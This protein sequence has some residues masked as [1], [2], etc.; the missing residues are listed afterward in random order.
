MRHILFALAI[1]LPSASLAEVPL[2]LFPDCGTGGACPSDYDPF[3]EWELGSGHPEQVPATSLVEIERP[4]GSGMWVDRAWSITTGRTDVI[5]AVMDS[6]IEWGQGELLNKHY[7]NA[8]ELPFPQD[9]DGVDAGTYDLN[10]DGVHNMEDWVADPRVEPDSA[11]YID[12]HA[13]DRK[14]PSDLI[15]VF[16]DGVDDDGNGYVDDISGWDFFWNDNDPYDEIQQDGYSHGSKEGRWSVAEGGDGGG[17]IGSCPNCMLLNIRVGDGF[18]ADV[19]HFANA[20]VF[21][22]DSGASVIQ[23]AL[24]TLN[25]TTM[26]V[27]AIEYA[28]DNGVTIIG[29]AADETAWHA[30]MPGANHHVVYTHAIRYD[31]IDREDTSTWFAYSNCTNFGGRL[32]ISVPAEGCSSGG[33]GRGAGVAGLLHSAARDALEAGVIDSALTA[34]EMYQLIIHQVHDIAFNPDDDRPSLYPSHPGWDQYFGY[35]R[36]DAFGAVTA[37]STG[38]IPPEADLLAPAWFTVLNK[39]ETPTVEVRGIAAADRQ[40]S[41]TW[42]LEVAGGMDPRDADFSQVAAGSGSARFEGVLATLDLDDVPVDASAVIEAFDRFDTNVTKVDK[43]HVHAATLRLRVIDG[44]GRLG[45]MRKMIFVQADP[46]LLPGM[47]KRV[48]VS[49]E[50]SLNLVDVDGDG[51]DDVVYV[52]SDGAVHVA[53]ATLTDKPGWPQHVPLL[54]EVD[55]DNPA[56]HLASAGYVGGHVGDQGRHGVVASPA[57]HKGSPV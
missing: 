17:S 42:E 20:A 11:G 41:Y 55:S 5:V 57:V 31:A 15:A 2:P 29:S 45:E 49:V 38:E 19:N 6:G 23:E 7:L 48:A 46:D 25:N 27:E 12:Q 52:T 24:G 54:D 18:V 44:E 16:S 32:D 37:I 40:G 3:G 22:V 13:H 50:P 1:L 47:P 28:W 8:G 9:A 51:I 34:N 43:V 10:G 4:F 33:T 26:A 21:A 53:D 56:N 35:G 39:T 14:D 30:N 36:P